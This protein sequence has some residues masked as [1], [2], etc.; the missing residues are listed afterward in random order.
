VKR[1]ILACAFIGSWSLVVASAARADNWPS[2]RG[3]DN[4]GICKETGLPT[5][6]SETQNLVWKLPLPGL[7]GSTPVVWG[8][9]IFLTSSKGKELVLLCAGTDG[10]LRWQRRLGMSRRLRIRGDEA[11]EASASPSTDGKHVYAFVGSGDLACFDFDGKQVWKFNAQDRYGK[12][13]IQHGMH[14]TPLLHEDRLYLLLQH[15]NAHWLIAL[16]KATGH[17][18][19]KVERKTDARGESK[20]AYTSPCLWRDGKESYIV[21]LGCDYVTAHR[22]GDGREVWRLGGLNPPDHYS[23]AFRIIA[24]PVAGPGLLVVPTA[25]GTVVVAIGPGTANGQAGSPHEQ[26]R[27]SRGSPD[28]PSPLV[29]GGLVYLCRENGV[30]ICLDGKTGREIYQ[31]ALHRDRYRASPVY[32]DGRIYLSSRDGTFSVVKAGPKFELLAV[33]QL[34]DVFTASPAISNGRIY[35][36]GFQAIY[37]VSEGGK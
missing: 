24:S 16:D 32:A 7:A 2:W 28:V 9:S 1:S 23:D 22:L 36:R 29:Y 37:A 6:W 26:W 13:Q 25:R 19:W 17:E 34:P 21:V 3:P 31:K 5:S 8:D 10:K 14:S 12:F 4:N 11:N 35:L 15:A 18:V 33:N 27:K 30:L 20:E